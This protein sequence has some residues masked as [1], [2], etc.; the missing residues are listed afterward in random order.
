MHNTMRLLTEFYR[1]PWALDPLVLASLQ[2]LLHRWA[3]SRLFGEARLTDEQIHAVIGDKAAEHA[4]RSSRS[5][6]SASDKMIAVLPVF[7]VIGHRAALVRDTSSGVNTSTEVLQAQFRSLAENPSVGAIVLDVDSPGGSV[8]GVSELSDTIYSA[9]SAKPVVAIANASAASAGYWIASAA[10]EFVVT[11]GG[12]AGSIGVWTAHE[13]WSAY[14]AKKGVNTTLVSAGKF[15]TEGHPYGPLDEV[16]KAAMQDS[17]EKYYGAFTGAVARHRGT[18]PA[19]VREG[20]GQG[21]MLHAEDA[22]AEGLADRVATFDEVIAD[23]RKRMSRKSG[24]AGALTVG[25][26]RRRADLAAL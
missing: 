11:P 14:L 16:A 15:K 2:G 10:S 9:R 23:L 6:A 24:S 3:D 20:F 12:Q 18:K 7:G 26:V 8:F 21:R 19:A 22:V 5:V 13:D 4:A 25:A 17:V 1:T